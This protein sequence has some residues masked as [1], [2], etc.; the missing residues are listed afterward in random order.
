MAQRVACNMYWIIDI[1]MGSIFTFDV[2]ISDQ[3]H[4]RV[5][6]LSVCSQQASV[7]W[8]WWQQSQWNWL[9]SIV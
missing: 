1:A 3:A 6:I 8:D 7:Q 5:Q 2:L 9:E 4:L